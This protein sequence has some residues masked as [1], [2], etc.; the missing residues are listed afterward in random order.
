MPENCWPPQ[1][2][3]SLPVQTAVCRARGNGESVV[4]V[5]VQTS[6]TGSYR[7][8]VP[9]RTPALEPPQTIIRLPVQ[10]AVCRTR[11]EGTFVKEVGLHVSATG[12]YR[13]PVFRACPMSP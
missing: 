6:F 8:P 7:P 1:T 9:V 3:I 12:S 5:G 10:T 13:P 11:T 2:T 4:D